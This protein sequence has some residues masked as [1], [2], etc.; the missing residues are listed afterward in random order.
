[1]EDFFKYIKK[2]EDIGPESEVRLVI[3]K[4][5]GEDAKEE[6]EKGEKKESRIVDPRTRVSDLPRCFD[7]EIRVGEEW[8][9]HGPE[10]K[11]VDLSS[12]L[13][14]ILPRIRKMDDMRR[15]ASTSP[16]E[17]VELQTQTSITSLQSTGPTEKSPLKEDKE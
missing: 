16:I 3:T 4:P 10:K 2:L 15:G 14:Q 6:E 13:S 8:K 9:R 1:M 7:L 11:S 5:R 12:I 17:T